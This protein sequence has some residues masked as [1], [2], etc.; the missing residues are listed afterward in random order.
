M[1]GILGGYG[2][3]GLSVSK[4]LYQ[5]GRTIRIGGRKI[6]AQRD[7]LAK[8]M[9]EA[10]LC[11]VDI[12]N[13]TELDYFMEGCQLVINC[14]GPACNI[15]QILLGQ[16]A[17]KKIP[18]IDIGFLEQAQLEGHEGQKVIYG[19]GAVPGLSG[20]LVKALAMEF[21]KVEQVQSFYCLRDIFT[22]TAA[23]DFIAGVKRSFAQSSVSE[24][25][26][27]NNY[28]EEIFEKHAFAFAYE[29][30]ETR[31][32]KKELGIQEG[33][34]YAV[35]DGKNLERAILSIQNREVTE[36]EIKTVCKASKMDQLLK[37]PELIFWIQMKGIQNDKEISKILYFKGKDPARISAFMLADTAERFWKQ[38]ECAKVSM[39]A[40]LE[41]TK[42][43]I[44]SLE[45]QEFTEQFTIQDA[46]A[47]QTYEDGEI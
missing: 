41:V 29:D 26:Y 21:T 20:V 11:Q 43:T 3:I 16:S 30:E 9:P 6:E 1:I 25:A 31:E 7:R 38:E 23:K 2:R 36:D 19:S 18:L 13:Q 12:E 42:E 35:R 47:F 28:P 4:L 40:T 44:R 24:L 33:H 15:S 10:E 22:E 39:L 8:L 14:S 45:Q 34:W 32:L 17:F 46:Q 5:K 27:T 37:E